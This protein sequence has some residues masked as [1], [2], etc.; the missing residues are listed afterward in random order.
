MALI[1]LLYGQWKRHE[2]LKRFALVV[3]I[4]T[5]STVLPT[6]LTGE[7]AEKI[8]KHLPG[9]SKELIEDHEEA[10]GVSLVLTLIA[11]ALSVVALM[12]ERHLS[13]GKIS[14]RA[15]TVVSFV[16]VISLGYTANLG[17]KIRHPEITTDA[18]EKI[19]P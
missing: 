14:L 11:G 6:Y 15:V 1:F 13:F 2:D 5:A 3:L 19:H 16:A 4:L 7:P 9:I 8:V 10:A 12:T 17:G 18:V